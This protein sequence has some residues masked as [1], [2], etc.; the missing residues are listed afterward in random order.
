MLAII[1]ITIEDAAA[2]LWTPSLGATLNQIMLN[3]NIIDT[4]LP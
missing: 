1:H 3:K 2:I 4:K